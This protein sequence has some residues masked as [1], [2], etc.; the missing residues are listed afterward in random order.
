MPI[1]WYAAS[2]VD[3]AKLI[4]A[5][6]DPMAREAIIQAVRESQPM[7]HGVFFGVLR[8]VYGSPSIWNKTKLF[9]MRNVRRFQ[10]GEEQFFPMGDNSAASADA[11]SWRNHYVPRELLIGKALVLLWPHSPVTM[12]PNYHRIGLIR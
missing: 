12:T 8:T 6:G 7:D 4:N 9:Q 3:D 5:V 1:A 10:L 2:P 11:R